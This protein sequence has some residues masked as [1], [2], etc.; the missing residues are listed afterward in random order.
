M[1]HVSLGIYLLVTFIVAT[2]CTLVLILMFWISD[3]ISLN[4]KIKKR[5][6][7]WKF[8]KE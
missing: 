5:K 8:P 1:E 6:T 3:R 4:R 7:V 2:L